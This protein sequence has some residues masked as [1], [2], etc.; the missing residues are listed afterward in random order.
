M[1]CC[2]KDATVASTARPGPFSSAE[3]FARLAGDPVFRMY[4]EDPRP[5]TFLSRFSETIS[6]P[7]PDG[8][9]SSA[10]VWKATNGNS[11]DWLLVFH[12]WWGLNDY[13]KKECEQL[14]TDLGINVMALD[15]YDGK[16]ATTRD[17]AVKYV[18]SAKTERGVAIVQ[19]AL[20]YL[21]KDAKVYTVGWCYGGGWSLQA[22]LLAGNQAYGC[23]M[24]YGMP[25]SDV[26]RLKALHADVLGIFANKDQGI[27]PAVVDAFA[28]R[29]KSA[30]K[31]L[32]LHRYDAAHAFA[33]PSNPSYNAEAASDAYKF[34][35]AFLKARL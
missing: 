29:M 4:H 22:S 13:I 15:L 16:V 25:E 35:L 26:S 5:F 12:E 19:G 14:W 11:H 32:E 3:A 18:Q 21:G 20:A 9:T 1:N 2:V 31:S 17:S 7:T 24:Y 6:F 34:A 30:G 28:D 8:G 33:N 23:V 27:T 10:L